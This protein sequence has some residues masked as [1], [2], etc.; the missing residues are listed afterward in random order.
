MNGL[1]NE[2]LSVYLHTLLCNCENDQLSISY[3]KTVIGADFDQISRDRSCGNLSIP[4]PWRLFRAVV[5]PALAPSCA[6]YNPAGQPPDPSHPKKSLAKAKTL[7]LFPRPYLLL[8][9]G[10]PMMNIK[11]IVEY[12]I[13]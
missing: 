12:S 5:L 4:Q 11:G 10:T 1:H 6:A 13:H 7:Y 2:V 8:G 3:N 9:Y